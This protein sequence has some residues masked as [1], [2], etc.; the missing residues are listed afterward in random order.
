[1]GGKSLHDLGHVGSLSDDELMDSPLELNESS[2]SGENSKI[3][4]EYVQEIC[5]SLPGNGR[6]LELRS[7]MCE[8]N[9]T[10]S[11]P[12]S[13]PLDF[14]CECNQTLSLTRCH[15]SITLVGVGQQIGD[16]ELP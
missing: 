3:K 16:T 6:K 10:L 8:C 7:G 13:R 14:A 12:H 2:S 9:Q 5:A 15:S 1:M 4:I 11:L